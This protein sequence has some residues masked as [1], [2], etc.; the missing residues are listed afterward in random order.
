MKP[1]FT[2]RPATTADVER[3]VQLNHALFQEDAGQ[4]DPTMNLNWA[5]EEGGRFYAGFLKREATV[6][7]L[8]EVREGGETTAVVGYLA[9][10]M[11]HRFQMRPIDIAELDSMYIIE[12]YRNLDLGTALV[13]R[14]R[15]WS[16][17]QGAE[18]IAVTAYAANTR[19]LTFY[20]RLGFI[21]RDI[22]LELPLGIVNG[23]LSITNGK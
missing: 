14:F 2:I 13:A 22:T 8:I 19:A 12:A 20:Q 1:R 11:R 23:K 16:Q 5:L 21:P 10:Q 7:L 15:E 4:R 9:G 3:I 17:E 6:V 18:R